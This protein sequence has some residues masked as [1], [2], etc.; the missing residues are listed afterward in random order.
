[1]GLLNEYDHSASGRWGNEMSCAFRPGEWL[2]YT[3]RPDEIRTPLRPAMWGNGQVELLAE[4]TRPCVSEAI[5]FGF[6]PTALVYRDQEHL[7]PAVYDAASGRK[8]LLSSVAGAGATVTFQPDRQVWHYA[9]EDL[10]VT[11]SLVLPRVVPGYLVEVRVRPGP[12]NRSRTWHV[13][14]EVRGFHGNTLRATGAYGDPARARVV[15]ENP[16]GHGE[17]LGAS[18]DA[19]EIRLGKDGPLATDIM[20]RLPLRRTE[21]RETAAVFLARGFGVDKK[22]AGSAVDELVSHPERRILETADWWNDYLGRVPRLETPD[23]E[24]DRQFLWSWADFRMNRIEFPI[25]KSPY[26]GLCAANNL[27]LD[28]YGAITSTDHSEIQSVELLHDPRTTRNFMM[29]VLTTTRKEGLLSGGFCGLVEY[30]RSYACALGWFLGLMHKYLSSTAD[31]AI[32]ETDIGG[33]TVLGRLEHATQEVLRHRDAGTGLYAVDDEESTGLGS[34]MEAVSR[35]RGGK[36]TFFSD[37]SAMVQG[38][39]AA[40]AEVQDLAGNDAAARR[41]RN[42]AEELQGCIRDRLWDEA[43]GYFCDLHADGSLSNQLTIGG[44]MTGLNA[45]HTFRPG[46]LA[47]PEQARRLAARCRHPDFAGEYGVLSLARSHPYYDPSDYKGFSGGFDMHYCNQVAGG[48]YAAGCYEEA[49]RQL[50]KTFRRI[51]H[52]HGLGPR[53]RGESYSETGEILPWRSVNYPCLLSVLNIVIDGAFGLRWTRDALT[54]DPHPPWPWANLRNLNVRGR[55]LDIEYRE[56][57]A[58]L[59]TADGK[60]HAGSAPGSIRIPWAFF[61]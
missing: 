30:E 5:C 49:H 59:A 3:I 11:V 39:F 1:M 57:A 31:L 16:A 35:Y 56:G 4:L 51:A 36:G 34:N 33:T 47:T 2:V 41:Y 61:E 22:Q 60:K 13:Y 55:R 10:G 26:P 15:F 8:Y 9:F 32:L 27:R 28:P 48:L 12:E 17:A 24:F 29:T 52:N 14:H 7:V 43:I 40:M 37:V 25:G 44:L 58:L 21:G 53:Y 45:N 38:S 46:G 6:G 54:A 50:F 42:L 20:V 23:E 18:T 19:D